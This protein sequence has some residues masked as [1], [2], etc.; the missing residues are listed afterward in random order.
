MALNRQNLTAKMDDRSKAGVWTRGMFKDLSS[1]FLKRLISLWNTNIPIHLPNEIK[2]SIPVM[3][4]TITFRIMTFFRNFLFTHFFFTLKLFYWLCTC[5]RNV[6][7]FFLPFKYCMLTNSYWGCKGY[8]TKKKKNAS[9][10][11]FV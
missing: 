3:S 2:T 11:Q 1:P 4:T 6:E 9:T 5:W 10:F 8:R 7:Q